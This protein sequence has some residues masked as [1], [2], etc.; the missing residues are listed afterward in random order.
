MN[1]IDEIVVN[2]LLW[3]KNDLSTALVFK[4]DYKWRNF[5]LVWTIIGVN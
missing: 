3:M 2:T 4:R 1:E 5:W